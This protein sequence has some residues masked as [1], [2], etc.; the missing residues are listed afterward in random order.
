MKDSL[1]FAVIV[2]SLVS[3]GCKSDD[4]VDMTLQMDGSVTSDAE[5]QTDIQTDSEPDD[6]MNTEQGYAVFTH[7]M[8]KRAGEAPFPILAYECE[9]CSFDQWT[10][11]EPPEGW[12]KGP[13]QLGLFSAEHSALRSYPEVEDHPDSVDFLDEVP[14]NEYRII[15]ITLSGRLIERGAQGV[16]VESQVQ[17]D[18]DLFT[19]SAGP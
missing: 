11:I 14:G 18:T 12:T 4:S 19:A 10:S 6:S 1:L 15:A 16:V 17:R 8:M 3:L 9:Q 5:L 2:V 13:P 7:K